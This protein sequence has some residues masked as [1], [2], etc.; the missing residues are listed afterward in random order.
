LSDP[1]GRTQCETGLSSY[2]AR[3]PGFVWSS[4]GNKTAVSFHFISLHTPEVKRILRPDANG[5]ITIVMMHTASG[6]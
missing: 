5:I 4:V 3:G 2:D 6:G 1:G